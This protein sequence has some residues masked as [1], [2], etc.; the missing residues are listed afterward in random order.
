MKRRSSIL[1]LAALPLLVACGGGTSSGPDDAA[2]P[3]GP[4]APTAAAEIE[5]ATPEGRSVELDGVGTVV[6][7]E[8][9]TVE[10]RSTGTAA[11]QLVV[12]FDDPLTAVEITWAADDTIS[13]DEQ[14]WTT[15]QAARGNAAMSDYVR[16]RVQ[17]PGSEQSVLA[18][19]TEEVAAQSGTSEVDAVR[20][21]VQDDAR[22]TVA[23]VAVAPA[24]SLEGSPA[25]S[26]V[27]SL[28]LG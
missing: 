2:T 5:V 27:L 23:A 20:L 13:V 10:E 15:E 4:H 6:V 3:S 9:A 19:W 8:G 11:R 21:V 16:A 7:P 25:E 18:R 26:V 28:A 12:T 24:G 1:L 14:T 22:T 17:W